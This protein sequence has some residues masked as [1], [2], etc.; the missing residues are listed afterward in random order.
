MAVLDY[1]LVYLCIMTEILIRQA[2]SN[3][4]R[5]IAKLSRQTFYDTFAEY[6]S[7]E[8]M[9]KFMHEQFSEELLMKEVLD[10]DGIFYLAEEG[11]EALGYVRLREGEKYPE[12]G[13]H[14]SIEIARIYVDKNA[15]GKGLGKLLMD[16]SI[17]TARNMGR[18]IVWLGVWEKN[19]RALQFYSKAGFSKFGEHEFVLGNDVQTDWLM[20]KWL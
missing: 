8:D 10:G 14:P 11:P 12:F 7:K 15:I 16:T 4:A 5:T 20:M 13:N 17:D 18:K 1:C 9:D 6:N 19:E 3:D 2:G